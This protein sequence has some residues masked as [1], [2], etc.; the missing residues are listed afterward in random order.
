MTNIKYRSLIEQDSDYWAIHSLSPEVWQ[1]VRE[2][3]QKYQ[4]TDLMYGIIR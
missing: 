4:W 1:E 2:N 3:R